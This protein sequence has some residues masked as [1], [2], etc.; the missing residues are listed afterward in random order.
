MRK[1]EMDLNTWGETTPPPCEVHR[2]ANFIRCGLN[3]LACQSFAAYVKSGVCLSPTE[4][5]AAIFDRLEIPLAPHLAARTS[6]RK[7]GQQETAPAARA[8]T[9]RL[10][11]ITDG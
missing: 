6:P 2:C 5:T 1:H 9:Y 3:G 11:K 4:P 10:R 8:A 7:T